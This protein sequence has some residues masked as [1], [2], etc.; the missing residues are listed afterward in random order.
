PVKG[1]HGGRFQ[2][3]RNRYFRQ[4]VRG[5]Q[6][7]ALVLLRRQECLAD[8]VCTAERALSCALAHLK[9]SLRVAVHDPFA[10][11]VLPSLPRLSR[12]LFFPSRAKRPRACPAGGIPAIPRRRR[13]SSR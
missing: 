11:V 7:P 12:L 6:P 5:R 8:A 9:P 4:L 13:P 3:Q 10:H 2:R 1:S